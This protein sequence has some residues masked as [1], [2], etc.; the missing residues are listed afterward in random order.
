LPEGVQRLDKDVITLALS[1]DGRFLVGGD[2]AGQALLWDLKKREYL[3]A[4]PTPEDGRIGRV[5]MAET[6]GTYVAGSFEKP[7]QPMRAWSAESLSR[8]GVYGSKGG[9]AV[10]V[11]LSPDGRVAALLSSSQD[12][13]SQ[14]ASLWEIGKEIPLVEVDVPEARVGAVA[15]NSVGT[16]LVLADGLG[17]LTLVSIDGTR[18]DLAPRVSADSVATRWAR[19]VF[20]PL[21]VAEGV[22]AARGATV[23]AFPLEGEAR[24]EVSLADTAAPIRGLHRVEGKVVAVTRPESGG[25]V[26]WA[27]NGARVGE[28]E[29]GCRC[30]TH[31]VSADG[32]MAACGCT[33]SSEIHYGAPRWASS[34]PSLR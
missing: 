31:A 4:D 2:L 15:V 33:P 12:G 27:M 18:R 1:G 29:S 9:I 21:D 8:L 6:G 3:W 24:A 13:A 32:T 30:E 14:R 19:V 22:W 7:D 10:D 11:A 5:A 25:L 34:P 26:F 17:G 28:F 20:G 23:K 16:K